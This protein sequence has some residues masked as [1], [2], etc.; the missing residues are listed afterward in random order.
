MEKKYWVPSLDKAHQILEMIA[1]EPYQFRLI[2]ISKRL[3]IHKSSI[4][5]LLRTMEELHWVVRDK[6][7]TYGLGSFLGPLGSA[8]FR[9]FDL[10]SQFHQ[11]A[12]ILKERLGETLQLA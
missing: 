9:Q 10:V 4:F 1:A 2:D 7:D 11:E 8:Y 3:G 12:S 6:G 5:S